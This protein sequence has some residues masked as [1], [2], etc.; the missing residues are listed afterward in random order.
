[1]A[2]EQPVAATQPGV[3]GDT[4][5]D[6]S[7]GINFA[8][9]ETVDGFKKETLYFHP[10]DTNLNQLNIGVVGDLGTGKTQLLKA[11]IYRT[12]KSA[13]A[14]RNIQPRFLIFDYK[15]DYSDPEFVK[16]VG[17]KVV[18]PHRLPINVFDISNSKDSLTPWLDRF[19]FFSDVLDKI[20]PGIGPVQRKLLKTA[21]KQAYDACLPSGRQPTIYD[22]HSCYA[23]IIGNKADSPSA[24]LEDLV[25]REMFHPEPEKAESFEAF[26][27]GVVVVNLASLGQ[28]DRAKNML[29][30]VMLNMFYEHMLRIPKRPYVGNDPQLRAVDSFLL[31]D[32]ADNIMRYEFDV[33]RKVLLQGREF[34]VG[35][36][37]A[38][39][40]LRHF[41][42]GAT[43]YREPLLTWFLHK[44]P[45]VTPNE[46]QALGMTLDVAQL[47]ERIK[48]LPKHCCLYKTLGVAGDVI[49]G[50]PFYKLLEPPH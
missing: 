31:V 49:Q 35:V 6:A 45:N 12:S 7:E 21:V 5:K 11:L 36:I 33:L 20:Y 38:S 42:A 25:D 17:A 44:V 18:K 29:V 48:T 23:S 10:S 41:K 26:L 28:D 40:Y 4:A 27:N 1:V 14:N 8:V 2:V 32:E 22:V 46:L 34:G 16:A 9:G 43:D 37:L 3:P 13:A 19:N 47:A 30:A 15:K 24:I 50:V 39:Q